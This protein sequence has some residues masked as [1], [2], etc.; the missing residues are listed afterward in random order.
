MG[1][2]GSISDDDLDENIKISQ[3]CDEKLKSIRYIPSKNEC[4]DGTFPGPEGDESIV[5]QKYIWLQG[6]CAAFVMFT[7]MGGKTLPDLWDS[8]AGK[9]YTDHDT[10]TMLGQAKQVMMRTIA[11]EIKSL[12]NTDINEAEHQNPWAIAIGQVE[13]RNLQQAQHKQSPRN[14]NS[15]GRRSNL[16][17]ALTG[18]P[19]EVFPVKASD[20]REYVFKTDLFAEDG[21]WNG[22][23]YTKSMLEKIVGESICDE[24]ISYED[25]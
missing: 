19:D 18:Q 12:I 3:F 22:V 15:D 4:S 13:Y 17:Y 14:K 11:P 9:G 6:V 8:Y 5:P 10:D 2:A 25:E 1:A 21:R 16:I 7:D 23:A 20:W 24:D